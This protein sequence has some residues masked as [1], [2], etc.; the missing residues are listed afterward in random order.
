MGEHHCRSCDRVVRTRRSMIM[1]LCA[2]C[3][4]A[5][6]SRTPRPEVEKR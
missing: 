3:D 1:N 4:R 5:S 2:I 6:R